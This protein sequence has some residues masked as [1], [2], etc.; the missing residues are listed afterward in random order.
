MPVQPSIGDEWLAAT[1]CDMPDRHTLEETER[2]T[3]SDSPTSS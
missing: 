1:V 2:V 3:R